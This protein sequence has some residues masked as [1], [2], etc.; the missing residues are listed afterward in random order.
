MT[1]KILKQSLRQGH[2]LSVTGRIAS[3]RRIS[4]LISIARWELSHLAAPLWLKRMNIFILNA[5]PSSQASWAKVSNSTLWRH[6]KSTDQRGL[7]VTVQKRQMW[8]SSQ[9]YKISRKI[10]RCSQPIS[11][12]KLL[13]SSRGAQMGEHQSDAILQIIWGDLCRTIQASW[14]GL[15]QPHRQIKTQHSSG[16]FESLGATKASSW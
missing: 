1:T 9:W 10:L 12:L 14:Q 16:Q 3:L 13:V 2:A 6:K 5:S 4:D 7:W 15:W 11:H 8:H